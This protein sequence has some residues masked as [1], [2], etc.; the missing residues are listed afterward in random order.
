MLRFDLLIS[1]LHYRTVHAGILVIGSKKIDFFDS[2]ASK[3]RQ[4][5]ASDLKVLD[6]VINK[7]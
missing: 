5:L 2:C 4:I 6:F 3:D 7:F 1:F